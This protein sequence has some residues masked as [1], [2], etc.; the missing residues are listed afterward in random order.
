MLELEHLRAKVHS[1]RRRRSPH[2]TVPGSLEEPNRKV[3]AAT[4]FAL[5]NFGS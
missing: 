4:N 1:D 5:N 2:H 3:E